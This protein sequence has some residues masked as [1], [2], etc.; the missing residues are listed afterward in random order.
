MHNMPIADILSLKREIK[1]TIENRRKNE[2]KLEAK[3]QKSF[4]QYMKS[5]HVNV[6]MLWIEITQSA[7]HHKNIVM[8]AAEF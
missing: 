8:S 2:R 6:D 3:I 5:M 7:E 1:L 4:G